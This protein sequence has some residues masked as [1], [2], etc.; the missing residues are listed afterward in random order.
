MSISVDPGELVV[1]VLFVDFQGQSC[2]SFAN[3]F[4]LCINVGV[5]GD[6]SFQAWVFRGVEQALLRR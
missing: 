3:E 4:P 1:L 5:A 2:L 6:N